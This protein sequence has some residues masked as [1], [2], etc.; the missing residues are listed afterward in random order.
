MLLVA[1][2][3]LHWLL[4]C[5]VATT[6]KWHPST[7]ADIIPPPK[8]MMIHD[9][10]LPDPQWCPL[11]KIPIGP[12]S[13]SNQ[14]DNDIVYCCVLLSISPSQRADWHLQSAICHSLMKS[15]ESPPISHLS[16]IASCSYVPSTAVCLILLWQHIFFLPLPVF[17][18][19]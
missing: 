19:A 5:I 9:I 13:L 16:I 18:V 10:S 4:Y 8:C 11:T 7:I 12:V 1:V 14:R 3:S 17:V 6:S 2:G 15:L